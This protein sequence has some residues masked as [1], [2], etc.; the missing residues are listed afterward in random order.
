MYEVKKEEQKYSTNIIYPNCVAFSFQLQGC[1]FNYYKHIQCI[2]FN[3]LDQFPLEQ[4]PSQNK[5]VT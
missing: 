5:S 2:I 3:Q 4:F 1:N